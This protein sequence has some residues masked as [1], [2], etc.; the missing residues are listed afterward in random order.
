MNLPNSAGEPES[1]VPPKSAS[2]AFIPGSAMTALISVFSLSMT[3]AGVFL[4]AP[5]PCQ[6]EP[7]L[8]KLLN[9]AERHDD[10]CIALGAALGFCIGAYAAF[11]DSRLAVLLAFPAILFWALP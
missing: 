5:T 8:Q 11:V 3:A 9:L 1:T 10:L 2:R 7:N 6:L 4:G